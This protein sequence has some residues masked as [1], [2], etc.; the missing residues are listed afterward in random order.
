MSM[1]MLKLN[2]T[3]TNTIT[4]FHF[5]SYNWCTNVQLSIRTNINNNLVLK[6]YEFGYAITGIKMVKDFYVQN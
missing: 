3:N 6:L 5:L 4:E 2:N 1:L